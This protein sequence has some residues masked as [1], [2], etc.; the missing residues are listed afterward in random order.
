MLIIERIHIRRRQ[1]N[2]FHTLLGFLA[3]DS[4]S[5]RLDAVSKRVREQ[6]GD[7]S[8]KTIADSKRE[9]RGD[10]ERLRGDFHKAIKEA[11]NNDKKSRTK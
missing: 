11:S 1:M 5:M 8:Y 7:L 10:M 6:M 2:I 4:D 3:D 9:M